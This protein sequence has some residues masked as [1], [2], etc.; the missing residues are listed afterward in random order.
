MSMSARRWSPPRVYRDVGLA[1]H[2]SPS[3]SRHGALAEQGLRRVHGA[4]VEGASGARGRKGRRQ[5]G[6]G[7]GGGGA[8]KDEAAAREGRGVALRDEKGEDKRGGEGEGAAGS[9]AHN[10]RKDEPV[11]WQWRRTFLY[12]YLKY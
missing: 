12:R 5:R 4:G 7:K 8:E 1:R 11:L 2:I 9:S 10:P 3:G 6:A